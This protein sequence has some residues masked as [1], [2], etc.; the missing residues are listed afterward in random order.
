MRSHCSSGQL[1]RTAAVVDTKDQ[2]DQIHAALQQRVAQI[3]SQMAATRNSQL[4][5]QGSEL[6]AM[7]DG[8][9]RDAEA[10]E[11]S[12]Q[13]KEIATLPRRCGKH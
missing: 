13:A 12:P 6:V 2:L 9:K 10:W 4:T 5:A 1:C 8:A 3:R 11:N 7:A